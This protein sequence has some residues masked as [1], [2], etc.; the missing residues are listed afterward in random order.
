[1][2]LRNVFLGSA[3]RVALTAVVG[4]VALG[5]LA[6]ALGLVGVPSVLGVENAFGPVNDTT[7]TIETD[8][9]V[10]NPNPV[11]VRLGGVGIDYGVT[12]NDVPMASGYK[13][14]VAIGAGNST[15]NFTTLMYN[16]RIPPWWVS[17]IESGER[18]D[19]AVNATVSSG[20]LGQSATVVPARRTIETDIVS[21][22]NSTETR[23]VNADTPP[24]EDPVAYVNRTNATWGD[25]N[26]SATPIEVELVVYN[27][28]SY[29][30]T[31]SELG[32]NITMNDVPMGE[33]RTRE[34]Y[35]VPP[36]ST[37][38]I[39][40][41]LLMQNDNLDEWWVSHLE[42]NQR[43]DL[44]VGFTL[45]V[46]T[47]LTTLQIPLS[48]L[49]SERTIETDF[50]GNKD[51]TGGTDAG[52]SSGGETTNGGSDDE[53]TDDGAS[54]DTTAG[55]GA[56]DGDTTATDDGSGDET[57]ATD[58]GSGGDTTNTTTSDDGLLAVGLRR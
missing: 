44:E 54:D 21:Q 35:T 56:L 48:G 46:D 13:Q 50:F 2:D 22:F 53:A 39:E 32:Y 17:H 31:I 26:Q 14:G 7:T 19:L 45:N 9:R 25:V 57:T 10:N 27:P 55:D 51:S 58:G 37:Q 47:E 8:L 20:L 4:L 30:L 1:M 11:G 49:T 23:P 3:F 12:M 5:G 18:T 24:I 6:F 29:P 42:R 40:A 34:G 33:G 38:T 15:L 52:G 43:T 28:K 16:D 36:E 41:T